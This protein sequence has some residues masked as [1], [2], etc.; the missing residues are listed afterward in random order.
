MDWAKGSERIIATTSSDAIDGYVR[1]SPAKS[2][3]IGSMTL[4]ALILC[5]AL[6]SWGAFGVFVFLSAVTL[7]AGHSVGM[8]R[9]LIHNSF[10]CPLWLERALVYSGVLVGMAGPFGMMRQHDLRDWAQRQS[11]C[12]DYLCHGRGFWL[13]GF[14]QLHCDLHLTHPPDF[15]PEPRVA[16][17]RFYASMERTWM[18]QQLPVAACL[19]ALGGWGWVAW[20]VAA[21][22]TA[23]VTGHWLVGHFAHKQ[24]PMRWRVLGAGVQGHDVPIA[25]LLSMG[26]SWHNNH[27][28]LPGSARLGLHEDQPDPGWW[29]ILVLRRLG[30]AWDIRTPETLPARSALV[31]LPN[32]DGGCPVCRGLIKLGRGRN[33]PSSRSG[34]L[35][36]PG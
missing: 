1:W 9:R 22:V 7:C 8:H 34:L 2:I 32:N 28:A 10:S 12:H 29:L 24:G 20:G 25:A 23:C 11:N 6:F 27:H 30:L 5:P 26:E 16:D 35:A 19:Y 21:R 18:W 13:D 31:R 36:L 17:D 15:Q 4:A 33:L 14:W 3:W